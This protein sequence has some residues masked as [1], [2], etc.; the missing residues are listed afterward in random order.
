MEH[1]PRREL[2][3]SGE[4]EYSY[5]Q[6]SAPRHE[7]VFGQRFLLRTVKRRGNTRRPTSVAARI[8]TRSRYN[9]QRT[10]R[11]SRKVATVTRPAYPEVETG[12][13]TAA[14]G[15]PRGQSRR[16]GSQ[17]DRRNAPKGY[18]RARPNSHADRPAFPD[19]LRAV[20]GKRNRGR[21]RDKGPPK[22]ATHA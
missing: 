18:Q 3:W 9:Q 15:M 20:G 1:V 5:W 4:R 6:L 21:A 12:E 13:F 10:G 8:V 7:K 16:T 19:R 22:P 17:C 14:A 2:R 11:P